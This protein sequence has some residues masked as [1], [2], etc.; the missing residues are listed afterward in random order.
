MLDDARTVAAPP[1]RVRPIEAAADAEV[2]GHRCGG[3]FAPPT[4]G[5]GQLQQ[6]HS[7]IS[8]SAARGPAARDGRRS[9]TDMRRFW[10]SLNVMISASCSWSS[11][12]KFAI[13]SPG[14]PQGKAL[15]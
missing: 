3:L 1:P 14:R 10:L 15:S 8:G 7:L 11:S 4:L 2:R 6:G 13:T 9:H 5:R 12:S